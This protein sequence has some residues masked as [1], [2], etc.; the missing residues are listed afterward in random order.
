MDPSKRMRLE[1]RCIVV[2]GVA[3][4]CPAH[5][6][7]LVFRDDEVAQRRAY[8]IA[9][10]RWRGGDFGPLVTQCASFD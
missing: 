8:A 7:C 10:A 3:V 1:A 4:E 6:G 2:Q 5:S 9:S